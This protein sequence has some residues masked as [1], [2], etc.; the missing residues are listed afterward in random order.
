MNRKKI[1][2][3]KIF[4]KKDCIILGYKWNNIKKVNE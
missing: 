3:K 4:V 1:N 2:V